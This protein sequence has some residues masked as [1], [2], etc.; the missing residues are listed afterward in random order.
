MVRCWE[1]VDRSTQVALQSETFPSIPRELL[2]E[3]VKRDDLT[4]R[5]IDLFQAVDRWATAECARKDLEP[6]K[7]SK[8]I[9]IGEEVLSNIRFPLMSEGQFAEKVPCSGLL[10][11]DEIIEL[12]MWFNGMS[13]SSLKFIKRPRRLIPPRAFSRCK[14]F[15]AVTYGRACSGENDS[16]VFSVDSPV[17][18]GGVRLFGSRGSAYHVSLKLYSFSSESN[19][20][21]P[22]LYSVH[23]S[24]TTDEEECNGYYGFDVVFDHPIAL[25]HDIQYKICAEISGSRPWYGLS[26]LGVVDCN[27]IEFRFPIETGPNGTNK[28]GGQFAEILFHKC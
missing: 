2:E 6:V 23:S 14:R 16:L 19:D 21:S 26:G 22:E 8:R 3:V 17:L 12:F 15:S 28:S 27:G 10:S 4:I 5:E 7:D 1:V 25:H 9:V 11:K 20:A 18:I 24:F 13:V